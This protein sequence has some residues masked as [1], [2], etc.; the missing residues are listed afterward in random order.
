MR[1]LI[2]LL[3]IFSYSLYGQTNNNLIIVLPPEQQINFPAAT[4]SN[5]DPV[6]D[7][8]RNAEMN[9][10]G[11]I[12][13]YPAEKLQ[14]LDISPKS[15]ML[16]EYSKKP[17]YYC[18]KAANLRTGASTNYPVAANMEKYDYVYVI[19]GG[20]EWWMVYYIKKDEVGWVHKSL[21]ISD[22]LK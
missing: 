3:F 20:Y 18:S 10:L 21:L 19:E 22:P 4:P 12:N 2:I 8:M 1:G 14:Y 15:E 17:R 6:G 7:A 11:K 16:R 5:Y 13:Y 9:N